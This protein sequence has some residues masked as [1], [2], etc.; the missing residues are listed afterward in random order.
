MKIVVVGYGAM[1]KLVCEELGEELLY[2][3]AL[4][5]KKKSLFEV[6]EDFDAIID[7]SHPANLDMILN[8]AT[9]NHKPLVIA[10]TGYTDEQELKIM[11]ASK[12]LPILKSANFALGVILLNRLVKEITPILKDDYDI[13]IIEAHHNKKIDSP[14]GTAKMLLD[15]I[16]SVTGGEKKAGRDGYSPRIPNEIGVHSV[17]GGTVV[18]EHE[19][20]YLGT[21]EVLTIKHQAQSKRIFAKGVKKAVHYIVNQENGLYDMNDVLFK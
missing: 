20:L 9:Q 13:E 19:V 5:C 17:R 6:T 7:F 16:I 10:T 4:E 18:G 11:E 21:D 1:G 14:S 2:P 8:Y 15:S 12:K 3:V